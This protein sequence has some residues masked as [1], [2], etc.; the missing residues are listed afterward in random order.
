MTRLPEA[1]V[2]ITT[3][4]L[5]PNFPLLLVDNGRAGTSWIPTGTATWL[6][7]GKEPRINGYVVDRKIDH[8]RET[9]LQTEW[10]EKKREEMRECFSSPNAPV[11][12][13][14]G[15]HDF[16][17]LA[18]FVGGDVFEIGTDGEWW[19]EI[20]GV[21]FGGFRGIPYIA[22]E[23]SDELQEAEMAARI[24][25]LPAD[26]D[27]LVTH[28]PLRGVLDKYGH[29]YGSV[30][31]ASYVTKKAYS[32]RPLKL[33]AF[34][35]IHSSAGLIKLGSTQFSNAAETIQVIDI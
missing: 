31:L 12:C 33:H 28:C 4:D 32:E 25:R 5:L 26:L 8:E 18:G 23:W 19:T 16:V 21:R 17:D 6:G 27:V 34:G 15:N 30:P 35:H 29:S 24:D 20:E 3:G 1:D 9:A 22:G 14:R 2:Y 11:V 13:V 10:V 7:R